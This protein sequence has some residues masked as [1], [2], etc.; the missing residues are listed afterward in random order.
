MRSRRKTSIALLRS[1]ALS[2][3]CFATPASAQ[4]TPLRVPAVGIEEEAPQE[5]KVET[6]ASPKYTAPLLD[7]PQTITVIPQAVI[8]DQNLL[9]LRDVLS[10]VP[11]IT[12]G[13]GEGGAGYGDSL[14]GA[15]S[16]YGGSGGVGGT[17]NLVSKVPHD[18]TFTDI[19][20]GIGTANYFRG[21]I[22]TN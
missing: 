17:I 6:P 21:I 1:T 2:F 9:S 14:N 4:N 5:Y 15:N 3:A 16:V 8:K 13:A 22:D 10:T 20:V 7:T 18:E 11:G 19:S 12:F